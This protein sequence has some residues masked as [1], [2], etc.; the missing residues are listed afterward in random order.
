MCIFRICS[1]QYMILGWSISGNEMSVVWRNCGGGRRFYRVLWGNLK[2]RV[3][4]ESLGV[5]GKIKIIWIFEI[6]IGCEW[7]GL[8]CLKLLTCGCVYCILAW[9]FRLRR[10]RG[11]FWLDEEI[12]PFKEG[13]YTLELVYPLLN[14]EYVHYNYWFDICW[15]INNFVI[16]LSHGT[17]I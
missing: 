3:H 9:T 7:T 10:V 6:Y 2:E 12:L 14:V 5:D 4:L 17:R 16:I 15:F 1:H 8:I 13:L 11:I